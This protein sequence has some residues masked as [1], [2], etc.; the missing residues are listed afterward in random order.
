MTDDVRKLLGGYATGT[1]SDEEKQFLYN[2]ALQ[3]D[4]LFAALADEQALKE[5][6]DDGAVR[7]QLLRATEEP[8]FS[9]AGAFREWFDQPKAKALVATGAVLIAIIGF[10]TMRQPVEE[11]QEQVAEVR[12][13]APSAPEPISQSPTQ[14]KRPVARKATKP[15]VEKDEPVILQAPTP[16]GPPPQ[17]AET[18]ARGVVG[19]AVSGVRAAPM[20]F[21]EQASADSSLPLRYELLLKEADGEFR[22]VPAGHAFTTGDLLRI[23]VTSTRNGAVAVSTPGQ[24]TVSGGVTANQATSLPASGGIVINA[25]TRALVLSFA[26]DDATTSLE[27]PIPRPRP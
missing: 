27:I 25:D 6:L 14:P 19:G 16:E 2:A 9:L 23:R 7:A 22:P 5:L 4:E 17:P 1:L 18:L 8:K 20:R 13:Q 26:A 10:N 3:D 12:Q 15:K 21:K 11:K 24:A